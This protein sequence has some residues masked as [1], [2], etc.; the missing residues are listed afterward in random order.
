M[1]P[2]A[3]E[4][5]LEAAAAPAAAEG[6]PAAPGAPAAAAGWLAVEERAAPGFRLRD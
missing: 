6:W 2:A 3:V 5:G 1:A 4:E